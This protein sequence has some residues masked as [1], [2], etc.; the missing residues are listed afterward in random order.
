MKSPCGKVCT[1][2]TV[3]CKRTC[4]KWAE[5]EAWKFE[6]YAEKMKKYKLESDYF[7]YLLKGVR[8][9]KKVKH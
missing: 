1:K 7:D 9:N 4:E 5:F 3:E 2:R 6:Q 8:K